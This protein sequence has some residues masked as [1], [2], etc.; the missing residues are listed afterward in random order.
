MCDCLLHFFF[1]Q[2]C[3][4]NFVFAYL[5]VTLKDF[6][7]LYD[8]CRSDSIHTTFYNG[9][10]HREVMRGHEMLSHPFA[11]ALFGNYVYW[12]DWRTN[13]VIRAN[14]WNGSD[15]SVI[16]RTLTQPFDIQ[17]LHPS[18]QPRGM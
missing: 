17:I 11:I 1:S 15:I 4:V 16:Q 12:T 3:N 2:D 14:K 5:V 6:E 13:A 10:D 8:L 7:F 9:T 18:R